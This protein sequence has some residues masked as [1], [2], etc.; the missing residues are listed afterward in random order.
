MYRIVIGRTTTF[1]LGKRKR[2]AGQTAP[3]APDAVFPGQSLTRLGP[4]DGNQRQYVIFR[5]LFF[6]AE[7]V[8]IATQPEAGDAGGSMSE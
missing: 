5:N 1:Q 6:Q 7:V 4:C 3:A 2:F 8:K